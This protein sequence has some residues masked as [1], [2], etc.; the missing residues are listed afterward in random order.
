[1]INVFHFPIVV[2]E[3]KKINNSYLSTVL[4]NYLKKYRC[5]LEYPKCLH[6]KEQS[7][8]SVF[9]ILDTATT[10]LKQNYFDII[11]NIFKKFKII[12][13]KSWVLLV[14]KLF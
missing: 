7:A 2:A 9:E 1:M 11:K 8:S 14:K 4:I 12:E 3:S 10:E 5:C 6:P 13:S